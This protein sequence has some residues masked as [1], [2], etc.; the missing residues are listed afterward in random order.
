MLCFDAEVEYTTT[1]AAVSVLT[2]VQ[3][4]VFASAVIAVSINSFCEFNLLCHAGD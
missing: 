4:L 2:D 3:K 1:N